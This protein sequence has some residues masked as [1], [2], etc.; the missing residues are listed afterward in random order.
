MAWKL[1]GGVSLRCEQQLHD[2]LAALIDR[3]FPS[4]Q[5]STT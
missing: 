2:S 1:E 3:R 4:P 5:H